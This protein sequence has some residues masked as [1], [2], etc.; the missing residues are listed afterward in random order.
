MY[1]FLFL[2]PANNDVN[3]RV[4]PAVGAHTEAEVCFMLQR[5]PLYVFAC[6][7][8][9]KMLL[10]HMQ[11]RRQLSRV[12]SRVRCF[13]TPPIHQNCT[14]SC[15]PEMKDIYIQN[16]PGFATLVDDNMA[17]WSKAVA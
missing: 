10:D 1:P 17:E 8:M 9:S 6:A 14:A 7:A 11:S 3:M 13:L 12:Y 4:T 5:R 16:K 15:V 2:F